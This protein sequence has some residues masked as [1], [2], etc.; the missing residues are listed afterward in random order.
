M[1]ALEAR[2]VAEV[3]TTERLRA[4]LADGP[5][6]LKRKE[7]SDTAITAATAAV[8][9]ATAFL[10]LKMKDGEATTAAHNA[11]T[12]E[13]AEMTRPIQ[14]SQTPAPPP[15]VALRAE[16]DSIPAAILEQ[17]GLSQGE[18]G[19]FFLA[20]TRLSAALVVARTAPVAETPAAVAV[21]V[22]PAREVAPPTGGNAA[23]PAATPT[24]TGP[25]D[26]MLTIP[27]GQPTQK[28]GREAAVEE[29]GD[30][31][32]N[33]GADG[34]DTTLDE[35]ATGSEPNAA[36]A[37]QVAQDLVAKVNAG[38]GSGKGLVPPPL[39]PVTGGSSG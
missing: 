2:K 4:L 5:R 12:L 14:A 35:L 38:P 7:A 29:D 39:V 3:P 21:A 9:K 15:V 1:A 22:A 18:L 37:L 10:Q 20:F 33:D 19:E 31:I 32:L 17:H 26:I 11:N 23:A 13:I 30:A 36:A 34:L 28:R 25:G 24:P 8:T 6:L 16:V 27:D